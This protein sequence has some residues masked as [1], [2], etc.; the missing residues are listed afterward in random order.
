MW[1]RGEC[2]GAK[3]MGREILIWAV[4][5]QVVCIRLIG[6]IKKE[7]VSKKEKK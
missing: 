5:D 6:L 3:K 7:I 2:G 4:K 1:L